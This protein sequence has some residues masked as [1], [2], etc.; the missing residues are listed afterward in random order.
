MTSRRTLLQPLVALASIA[1]MAWGPAAASAD[2]FAPGT[3]NQN[4]A[5]GPGGWS[6]SSSNSGL[7]VP[8]LLCPQVT[9]TF[10]GAGGA[11]GGG[12]G[13]IDTAFLSLASTFAGTSTGIFESPAFV[14]TGNGGVNPASATFNMAI[15]PQLGSLLGLNLLSDANYR[16]DL[17]D[18]VNG[19]VI[20]VKGP[21][22]LTNSAPFSAIPSVNIN[23]AQLQVGRGYKIRITTV[24]NSV[25][26]VVAN[27][28]VG[29]DNVVLSTAGTG[30]GGG[31]GN[32]SGGS[33]SGDGIYNS[34]T[35]AQVILSQGLPNSATLKGN[36][37]KLKV[38][39]PRKAAPNPCKYSLQGLSGNRKSKP[40]TSRK[41]TKIAAGKSKK[42]TV[43]V[44]PKF[45]AKYQ[46]A[47][48][49]FIKA[50]VSVGTIKA[51]VTKKVKV[52]HQ[53]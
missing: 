29:Y 5:T 23:P 3:N 36:K 15:R 30:S 20:Q 52:I 32:G 19:N 40:A 14:Y 47:K 49:V 2:T 6:S 53:G 37:L 28:D 43:K 44:K 39:C 24:Y 4:F 31:S 41:K 13:Y 38:K 17:V 51:T 18:Q 1:A 25:A 9:N 16:V 50:K 45:L 34:Q 46:K 33:G 26:T 12:D 11:D 27:G 10:V 7:C 22:A 21:T 48:K 35:L 42:V 8:L